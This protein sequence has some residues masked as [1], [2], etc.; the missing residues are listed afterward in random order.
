[1]SKPKESP[2][3]KSPSGVE[4][5]GPMN[6]VDEIVAESPDFVHLEMMSD[7]ALWMKIG[8]IAVRIYA[9][10]GRRL[11]VTAEEE[12]EPLAKPCGTGGGDAN[13]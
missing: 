10:K 13:G 11:I 9:T 2:T 4:V 1:M 8:T 3:Y 6:R 12:G 5:R 7:C